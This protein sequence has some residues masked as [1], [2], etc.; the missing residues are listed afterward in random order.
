LLKDETIRRAI[1]KEIEIMKQIDHPN[2]IKFYDCI[3]NNDNEVNILLEHAENGSV[4]NQLK[5]H[6]KISEF[7]TI[8][9]LKDVI[10]AVKYLHSREPPI[11]HRDIKPE[12][13]LISKNGQCKLADFGSSNLLD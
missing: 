10:K 5:I 1:M 2:I 12:N 4:F 9:Y 7:Q 8:K 6:D 3:E 13:I 11:L